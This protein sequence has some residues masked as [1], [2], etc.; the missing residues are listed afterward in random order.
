MGK[1]ALAAILSATVLSSVL[2]V[3]RGPVNPA[4]LK[5]ESGYYA[6]LQRLYRDYGTSCAYDLSSA[7][8]EAFKRRIDQ[9]NS[10]RVVDYRRYQSSP[11]FYPYCTYGYGGPN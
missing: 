10:R 2:A 11:D 3:P 1:L 5:I 7:E 6:Q 8:E 4:L 9:L